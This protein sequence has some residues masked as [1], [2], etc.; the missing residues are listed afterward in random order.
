MDDLSQPRL[1]RRASSLCASQPRF[2]GFQLAPHTQ[3]NIFTPLKIDWGRTC[4]DVA[5][6]CVAEHG[7]YQFQQVTPAYMDEIGLTELCAFKNFRC[8]E[9]GL[10]FKLDI[11]KR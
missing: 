11:F 2:A 9:H 1:L 7:G 8:E 10:Y 3:F 4:G 6:A 5:Y